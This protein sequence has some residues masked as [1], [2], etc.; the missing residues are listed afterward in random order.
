[1]L[2]A[3]VDDAI[4]LDIVSSHGR[5]AECA[6]QCQREEGFFHEYISRDLLNNLPGSRAC[7]TQKPCA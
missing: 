1:M 2:H 3:K 4:K 5:T 6:E 7:L